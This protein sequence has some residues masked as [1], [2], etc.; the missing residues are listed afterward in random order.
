M[1]VMCTINYYFAIVFMKQLKK[2]ITSVAILLRDAFFFMKS[3]L[4][5]LALPGRKRKGNILSTLF[6]FFV[7][8]IELLSH[9]EKEAF[10]M[11]AVF[12]Q[13]YI[14][15]GIIAVTAFLFLLS[16]IEWT[17]YKEDKIHNSNLRT[18]QLQAAT[19]EKILLNKKTE[20]LS[21]LDTKNVVS[22]IHP[23]QV[24]LLPVQSPDPS[25]IKRYLLI[26]SLL[27]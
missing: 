20:I 9:F 21:C 4:M 15:K 3:L 23:K 26:R 16:S 12:K 1:Y 7:G 5:H 19:S 10:Q 13:K 6:V 18:E 17:Y 14:R 11:A 25:T 27:I 22:E 2:I 24:F 8:T